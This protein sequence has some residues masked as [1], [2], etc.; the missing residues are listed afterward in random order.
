MQIAN[1]ISANEVHLKAGYD[2]LDV[3]A[4]VFHEF[5]HPTLKADIPAALKPFPEFD[6]PMRA[7]LYHAEPDFG[8][9]FLSL[10]KSF[11]FSVVFQNAPV[12]PNAVGVVINFS[13]VLSDNDY[14]SNSGLA[15]DFASLGPGLASV[16]ATLLD[17]GAL[18]AFG[19]PDGPATESALSDIVETWTAKA[20]TLQLSEPMEGQQVLATGVETQNTFVNG[21]QVEERPDFAE[22]RKTVKGYDAPESDETG[23]AGMNE[24]KKASGASAEQSGFEVDGFLEI[25]TGGNTLNNAAV[26]VDVWGKAGVI[27]VLGDY[28]DIDLI[29]QTNVRIGG[30]GAAS[31]G[32]GQPPAMET[33]GPVHS[34]NL[35]SMEAGDTALR[36]DN[37]AGGNP[38]NWDITYHDGDLTF[39]NWIVQT[40]ILTDNDTVIYQED[41]SGTAV[42]SG[43]NIL[44]NTLS[45]S[46]VS[47]FYDLIVID[48]NYYSANIITQANVLM[49]LDR[50]FAEGSPLPAETPGAADQVDNLLW[51]DAYIVSN[52]Q[53]TV[54]G[55][56]EATANGLS[57]RGDGDLDGGLL[58]TVYGA[59]TTLYDQVNVLYVSG[60]VFDVTYVE[61]TNLLADNDSVATFGVD[62]GDDSVTISDDGNILYNA[63]VIQEVGVDTTIR[64]AGETYSEAVLYQAEIICGDVDYADAGSGGL[65][66]EA[67]VFLADGMLP[68]GQ[69]ET[70][71]VSLNQVP[72]EV[73][74]DPMATL[75]A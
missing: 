22:V 29:S 4:D 50:L 46:Q 11:A 49:D 42:L 25:E 52:Y 37:P 55:L 58:E 59:S 10:P 33:A 71:Q 48:G 45:L 41:G 7:A 62:I 54:T 2:L 57:G 35:A 73:C 5:S 30:S 56:D 12:L 17:S 15:F 16:H 74:V 31:A 23:D 24:P 69:Q 20:E 67:V 61:Q 47:D 21:E 53:A 36:M 3:Q 40:N 19:T 44:S 63:A 51:N 13:N 32:A 9:L 60:N 72:D 65:A 70:E 39:L 18:H 64:V 27:T 38:I 14:F 8:P 43:G 68:F 6:L 75:V 28:Y 66:S 34:F 26:L 1:A